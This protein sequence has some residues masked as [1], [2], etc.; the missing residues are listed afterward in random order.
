[1]SLTVRVL[2]FLLLAVS[3]T[4]GQGEDSGVK[5]VTPTIDGSKIPR[6]FDLLLKAGTYTVTLNSQMESWE[7]PVKE[8]VI[9]ANSKGRTFW[10]VQ[11]GLPT[12]MTLTRRG[13]TGVKV[14]IPEL[15]HNITGEANLTFKRGKEVHTLKVEGFGNLWPSNNSEYLYVD[16]GVYSFSTDSH[17]VVLCV[18][19]NEDPYGWFEIV[20]RGL[21]STLVIDENVSRSRV[22]IFVTQN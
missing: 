22:W 2:L 10:K 3:D 14:L 11:E 18:P 8:V 1:M 20:E 4:M 16:P 13:K 15:E 6:P 19:G 5:V 9:F 17:S 21:S 12:I 7:F